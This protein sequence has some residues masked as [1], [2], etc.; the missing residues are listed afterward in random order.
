MQPAKE[1]HQRQR[2]GGQKKE[3]RNSGKEDSKLRQQVCVYEDE[4]AVMAGFR[5]QSIK[6]CWLSTLKGG[7]VSCSHFRQRTGKESSVSIWA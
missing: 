6:Q 7:A 1:Q 2:L 5:G 3:T 4:I